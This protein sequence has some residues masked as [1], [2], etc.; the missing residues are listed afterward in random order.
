MAPNRPIATAIGQ[1]E[2]DLAVQQAYL[3]LARRLRHLERRIYGFWP[4]PGTS[5]LGEVPLH[6]G[7]ALASLGIRVGLVEPRNRWRNGLAHDKLSVS[8][9]GE[10]MDVLAPGC[11]GTPNVGAIVEETL[12]FARGRY[13]CI[14]LDLSGLELVDVLEVALVPEVSIVLFVA[15][16]QIGEFA[17]ARI[18]RRLPAERVLGA[19]LMDEESRDHLTVA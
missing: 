9:L 5:G 1:T 16:G 17:L 10:A 4:V 11:A 15:Q 3:A 2:E 14:L 18:R 13:A 6:L 12:T 8:V 7:R 19:V